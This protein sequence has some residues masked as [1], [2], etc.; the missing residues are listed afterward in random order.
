MLSMDQAGELLFI[1]VAGT[2]IG[3]VAQRIGLPSMIALGSLVQRFRRPEKQG[4][5][6]VRGST[7]LYCYC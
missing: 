4:S 1:L 6:R 3:W 2:V 7:L 5:G